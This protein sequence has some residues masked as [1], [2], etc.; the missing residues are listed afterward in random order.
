MLKRV[1]ASVVAVG[2]VAV[3]WA[4]SATATT[5]SQRFSISGSNTGGHVY[6]SGPIAGSGR[7][8]VLGPNADKFVFQNGS[9]TVSHSVTT[10]NQSFDPRTCLSKF[11][12]SGTY[13]IASA[14]GA[15]RG[16][17]GS[18]TYTARGTTRG[19]DPK[20]QTT[21]YFVNASGWTTLP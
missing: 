8:I 10:Q 3:V 16:A 13:Q 1:A 12:E 7:D 18:G 4:G 21:R 17:T 6:A 15:Y 19:C 20:T 11:T 5:G 14:S 9:V 2:A